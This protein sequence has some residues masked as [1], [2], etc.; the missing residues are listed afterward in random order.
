VSSIDQV[1]VTS[2][3]KIDNPLEGLKGVYK[4]YVRRKEVDI[5][6]VGIYEETWWAL[7][8]GVWSPGARSYET[9]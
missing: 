1:V 8:R 5:D 6:L 7:S 9:L 2:T 4:G 3:T